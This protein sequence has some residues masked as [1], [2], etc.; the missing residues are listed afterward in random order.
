MSAALAATQRSAAVAMI[1][2]VSLIIASGCR[3][4][5]LQSSQAKPVTREL[6]DSSADA[7]PREPRVLFE[8]PPMDA[9]TSKFACVARAG[10]LAC[11]L[12]GLLVEARN[13]EGPIAKYPVKL[14]TNFP[15]FDIDEDS[16]TFARASAAGYDIVRARKVDGAETVVARRSVSTIDALVVA[17]GRAYIAESLSPHFYMTQ[18]ADIVSV[19]L[20]RPGSKPTLEVNGHRPQQLAVAGPVLGFVRG[21]PIDQ[22][23]FIRA[24]SMAP[25]EIKTY[26][27]VHATSWPSD[28]TFHGDFLYWSDGPTIQRTRVSAPGAIETILAVSE[29]FIEAFTFDGEML[30][31]GHNAAIYR[32]DPDGDRTMRPIAKTGTVIERLLRVSDGF[33]WADGR[34]IQ[35]LAG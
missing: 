26:D 29:K 11:A 31:F 1:A 9:H 5:E 23:I 30:V 12:D 20:T 4:R 27:A 13:V 21:T 33:L 28:L 18:L 7:G 2:V 22:T 35:G 19:D 6:P 16:V 15:A 8:A 25:K 14:D 17:D 10:R 34:R 24:G 32:V 3:R